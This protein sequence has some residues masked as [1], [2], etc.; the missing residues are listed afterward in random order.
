[1]YSE[2]RSAIAQLPE[3]KFRDHGLALL[4]QA[5]GRLAEA[6]T[7]LKRLAA[8]P[9]DTMDNVRLAEVYAFRGMSD[10]AFASLQGHRDVLER[11]E[12]LGPN[13]IRQFQREMRV[14]PF[15]TP[16]H[17]DPRWNALMIEPG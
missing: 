8:R 10:E 5:P 16:L 13:R 14:S 6:D 7:A 15:L 17:A 12:V 11:A 1:R 4:Y 9:V 3:G 2:A